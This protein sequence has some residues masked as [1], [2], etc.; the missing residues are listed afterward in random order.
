M[1]SQL[2][3]FAKCMNPELA[4]SCVLPELT[5]LTNDEEPAVR[6]TALE[7]IADVVPHLPVE[8][9]RTVAVPLVVKIFQKSLT[10][11]S[12]PDLTG[13]A[14]LLGKLSHQLKD[15]M[16]ADLRDW[17]V[18]FYCQLS[19]FDDPVNEGRPH[20]VATPTTTVRNG[21]RTECRRLCAYNFPAMV[22]MVGGGG[23]AVK[24]SSTHQ[25]LATDDSPR[26]RHTVASGYHEVVRLIGDKSMSAVGIYQKLLNSKSVEH[27]GIPELIGPLIIAEGVAG[28]CRQWRL[29]EQIV[30]GFSSLVHCLTTDQLYNKIVPILMK[31]ITGKYV[32]PVKLASCQSLAVVTRHLRKADQRSAVVDRLSRE[33]A[34]SNGCHNRLL[35]LDLCTIILTVFSRSFFKQH[36]FSPALALGNDSVV[37]VRLRLCHLLPALKTTLKLPGDSALLQDLDATVRLL[38]SRERDTN[39]TQAIRSAVLELDR[40]QVAME[41]LTRRTFFEADLIDRQKEIEERQLYQ[42]EEREKEREAA[43][44]AA[45]KKGRSSPATQRAVQQVKKTKATRTISGPPSSASPIV[46]SHRSGSIPTLTPLTITSSPSPSSSPSTLR[47]NLAV[48]KPK[49]GVGIGGT[50]PPAIHRSQSG[51][52]MTRCDS[53]ESAMSSGLLSHSVPGSPY[54]GK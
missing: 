28:S 37:N 53:V 31:I 43:T 17:F 14:R 29:H 30:T 6:E 11:V 22:Q 1:C 2:H 26:V 21:M 32:R 9:V 10:D 33:C 27:P 47:R 20:S 25:D 39:T 38:L 45:G 19:R 8:T 15:V 50:S 7:S 24:L 51:V 36:F 49:G 34:Q 41:T 16:T 23:Y 40:I 54:S 4:K 13:V 12:S 46:S 35:Y 52:S 44:T 48:P 42:W 3:I 18:K 5:E